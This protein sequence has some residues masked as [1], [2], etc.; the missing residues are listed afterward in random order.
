MV[1]PAGRR[2]N[3]TVT[4]GLGTFMAHLGI[5]CVV[6][7]KAPDTG[8]YQHSACADTK[9]LYKG[10]TVVPCANPDCRDKGANWVL[11]EKA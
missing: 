1:C 4:T 8:R 6:G 5:L 7:T 11:Q 3:Y 9:V 2:Q 10:K